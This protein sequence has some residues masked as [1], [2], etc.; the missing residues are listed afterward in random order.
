MIDMPATELTCVPI[1]AIPVA[2][3]P[4]FLIPN[5]C[6]VNLAARGGP[7]AVLAAFHIE[8]KA[9]KDHKRKD[10]RPAASPAMTPLVNRWEML[11]VVPP[12]TEVDAGYRQILPPPLWF[13]V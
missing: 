2:D 8:A 13:Q 11:P 12:E 4:M 9:K 3:K 7:A 6:L 10:D 1:S 5:W